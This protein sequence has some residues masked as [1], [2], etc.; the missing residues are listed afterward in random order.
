MNSTV[1]KQQEALWLCRTI[2][3]AVSV[4]WRL[5]HRYCHHWLAKGSPGTYAAGVCV[6]CVC[7]GGW[8]QKSGT[9]CQGAVSWFPTL[10]PSLFLRMSHMPRQVCQVCSVFHCQLLLSEEFWFIQG[11]W[12]SFGSDNW[13][14]VS[15]GIPVVMLELLLRFGL[16]CIV[17]LTMVTGIQRGLEISGRVVKL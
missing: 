13:K 17:A 14:K 6:V 16:V 4:F 15:G 12:T 7:K 1:Q 11:S 9:G 2:F 10:S 5:C 3:K 8:G